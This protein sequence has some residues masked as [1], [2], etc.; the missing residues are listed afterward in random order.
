MIQEF[1]DIEITQ[2]PQIALGVLYIVHVVILMVKNKRDHKVARKAIRTIN[3]LIF[4][5]KIFF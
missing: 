5:F 3:A 1:T 4:F 2:V